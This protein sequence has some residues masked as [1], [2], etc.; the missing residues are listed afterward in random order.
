MSSEI[1][2]RTIKGFV[3]V[4]V[5]EYVTSLGVVHATY[6]EAVDHHKKYPRGSWVACI[7]VELHYGEGQGMGDSCGQG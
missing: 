6:E 1:A 3:N 5:G 7:P 2:D 4:S